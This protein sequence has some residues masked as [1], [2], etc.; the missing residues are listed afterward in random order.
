MAKVASPID[1]RKKAYTRCRTKG[2][3][4]LT[5]G[6]CCRCCDPEDDVVEDVE[7]DDRNGGDFDIDFII[8][9]AAME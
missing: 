1:S 2:F 3:T 7:D 8:M 6:R 9:Y 5:L 4:Y